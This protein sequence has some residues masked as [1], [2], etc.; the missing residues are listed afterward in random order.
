VRRPDVLGEMDFIGSPPL[1]MQSQILGQSGERILLPLQS[2]E[3][4]LGLGQSIAA[5]QYLVAQTGD[6][7][8]G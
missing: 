6:H 1:G 8:P 7:D 3:G 5:Q 2:A 4:Q